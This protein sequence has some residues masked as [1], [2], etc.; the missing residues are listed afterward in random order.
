MSTERG[1]TVADLARRW[2]VSPDKV[3][4]WIKARQL[5]AIN[6]A[7]ALCARPRF[8]ISPDAVAAFER[9]RSAG[10]PPRP[11]R[12]KRTKAFDFYPD[13]GQE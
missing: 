6:T 10:A 7:T 9:Q 12:R 5:S 11:R 8:I 4:A 2:R 3:R 13:A 1:L